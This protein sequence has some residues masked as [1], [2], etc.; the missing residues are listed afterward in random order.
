MSRGRTQRGNFGHFILES[1]NGG[2]TWAGSLPRVRADTRSGL[3]RDSV[4]P[5]V[6]DDHLLVGSPDIGFV[7]WDAASG[8]WMP[9]QAPDWAAKLEWALPIGPVEPRRIA[10]GSFWSAAADQAEN[11]L[12]TR[13]GMTKSVT[14]RRKISIPVPT[15]PFTGEVPL[16]LKRQYCDPGR[17][18]IRRFEQAMI[19]RDPRDIWALTS[20]V[21]DARCRSGSPAGVHGFTE[22]RRGQIVT[23]EAGQRLLHSMDGGVSWNV[24]RSPATRRETPALVTVIDN[25][26]VLALRGRCRNREF[27]NVARIVRRTRRGAWHALGCHPL[28]D[29]RTFGL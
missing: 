28:A 27:E 15:P 3:F 29:Q 2:A 4:F 8:S 26:P 12:I 7:A 17:F 16:D 11:L 10:D 5:L 19:D 18:A 1:N 14:T 13:A 21:A 22:I 9:A 20:A 24:V 25:L 23:A 6:V